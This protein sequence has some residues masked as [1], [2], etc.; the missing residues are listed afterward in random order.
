MSFGNVSKV[1]NLV[2]SA[3]D[4]ATGAEVPAARDAPRRTYNCPNCGKKAQ[5]RS[6]PSRVYFAHANGVANDECELYTSPRIEYTGRRYVRSVPS[7]SKSFIRSDHLAFGIGPFGPELALFL[8]PVNPEDEWT[9][10][11]QITADHISRTFRYAHLK[12]G[13]ACKFPLAQGT[14]AVTPEGEVAEE[15]LARIDIGP[16]SLAEGQNLFDASRD[17]G[18]QIL[19]GES[20]YAGDSLWW[21]TR[22]EIRLPPNLEGLAS[23]KQFSADKEWFAYRIELQPGLVMAWQRDTLAK[24]LQRPVRPKRTRVWIEEPWVWAHSDLGIPIFDIGAGRLV[25]QSEQL[26][27]VAVRSVDTGKVMVSGHMVSQLTWNDVE[28]GHWELVVNG[29]VRDLFLVSPAWPSPS[30]VLASVDGGTPIDFASVQPA[31]DERPA[32]N[33]TLCSIDLT[34]GESSVA[35]LIRL[36]GERLSTQGQ[37]SVSLYLKAGSTLSIDKIGEA[38]MA[39]LPPQ[40]AAYASNLELLRQHAAWLLGVTSPTFSRTSERIRIPPVWQSDPVIR[41]LM[42]R[43]WAVALAPQVRQLQRLL[44]QNQ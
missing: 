5:L 37:Q 16:Q 10:N 19:P 34:W 27:D 25:I 2:R 43:V 14:W 20:V 18:K 40:S 42:D 32:G 3:I 9:G 31:L 13:R 22:N 6:G 17:L 4:S 26:V 15:Y 7:E 35:E 44:E 24:W 30:N 36:N 38:T 8:P 41:Q 28:E 11:L 29:V 39:P 23:I 1:W 12:Q 21:L 33:G